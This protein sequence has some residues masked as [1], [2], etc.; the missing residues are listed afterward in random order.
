M[1]KGK[2]GNKGKAGNAQNPKT[3]GY[4]H[5]KLYPYVR[6]KQMKLAPG[7]K[8][9][10]ADNKKELTHQ[11]NQVLSEPG[12]MAK[13]QSKKPLTAK[14]GKA[15]SKGT[16]GNRVTRYIESHGGSRGRARKI[17]AAQHTVSFGADPKSR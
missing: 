5:R 14:W 13:G 8:K 3:R 1:A 17:L 11:G 4:G 6:A 7:M 15:Q 9:F 10:V 12:E 16:S 2:N